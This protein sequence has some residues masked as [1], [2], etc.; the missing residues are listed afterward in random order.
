MD[1]DAPWWA[2]LLTAILIAAISGSVVW[3]GSRRGVR[4]ATTATNDAL[5]KV[6][7]HVANNHKVGLR[8]DLDEKFE[9]LARAIG[10]LADQ[11]EATRNDVGGLHSELRDAREDVGHLQRDIEGIRTDSRRARR[12]ESALTRVVSIALDRAQG[13][14]DEH[15]PGVQLRDPDPSET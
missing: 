12:R 13:V 2:N 5:A 3:L 14:I 7:D 9:G 6:L 10:S 8:D 11:Q 4:K 1:P 15:H